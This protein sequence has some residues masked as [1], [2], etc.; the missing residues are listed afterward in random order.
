MEEIA[1]EYSPFLRLYRETPHLT[2]TPQSVTHRRIPR[3]HHTRCSWP[4]FIT[5]KHWEA[6]WTK[7]RKPHRM[8]SG[9]NKVWASVLSRG[10]HLLCLIQPALNYGC[11]L[12]TYWPKF[13]LQLMQ[14][15][16]S[17]LPKEGIQYKPHCWE[18]AAS[19]VGKVERFRKLSSQTWAKAQLKVLQ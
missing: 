12:D 16:H 10:R 2:P 11:S 13:V 19:R 17:I 7:G 18:L 4:R 5:A 15:S 9:G 14:I 6:K 3:A 8:R 1:V